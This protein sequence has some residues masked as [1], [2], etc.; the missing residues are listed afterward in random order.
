LH[1]TNLE[2]IINLQTARAIGISI[3]PR[4]LVLVDGIIGTTV[5]AIQQ[6][7]ADCADLGS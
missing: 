1:S 2:F 5:N 4:L 7:Q 6:G 3:I